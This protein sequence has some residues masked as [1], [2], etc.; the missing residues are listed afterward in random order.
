ML[1]TSKDTIGE[2]WQETSIHCTVASGNV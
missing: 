1:E 2:V